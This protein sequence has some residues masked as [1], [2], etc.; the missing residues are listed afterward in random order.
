MQILDIVTQALRQVGIIDATE[1]PGAEDGAN[2]LRNL[3]RMMATMAEDGIDLGYAPTDTL[4]DTWACPL[5]AV[6]TIEALLSLKEASDRGIDP[7]LI[8]VGMA[9]RGYQRLLGR[10]VSAQIER[11]Q[12][13]TLPLGQNRIGRYNILTG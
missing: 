11:T 2:A 4:T 1:S 5:G 10:A 6:S 12:S 8:V 13:A 9:D 3:N 7:P